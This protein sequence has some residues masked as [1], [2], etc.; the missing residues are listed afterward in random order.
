[1]IAPLGIKWCR[2]YGDMSQSSAHE[3]DGNPRD[4]TLVD[5]V[6]LLA[7]HIRVIQMYHSTW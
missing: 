4:S 1:M 3:H 2:I 6:W 5:N 7:L